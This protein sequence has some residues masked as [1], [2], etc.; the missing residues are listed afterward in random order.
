MPKRKIQPREPPALPPCPGPKL[1]AF[2]HQNAQIK[3]LERLDTD[4]EGESTTQACVYKVEIESKVY[5][6]KIFKFFD[7]ETIRYYWELQLRGSVP[8]NEIIYYTD[9]FFAECRAYGRIKEARVTRG[10]REK[11]AVPCHGYLFLTKDDERRLKRD[12]VSLGSRSLSNELRPPHLDTN[13][14]RAIVKDFEPRPSGLNSKNVRLALRKLKRLNDIQVYN[15]DVTGWVPDALGEDHAEAKME[16]DMVMFDEAVIEDKVKTK[17]K[18][19]LERRQQPPRK[20]K[21]GF[22]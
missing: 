16:E 9:P 1:A 5:A 17:A 14:V 21:S 20:A 8:L 18:A 22:R 6:L 10:I 11:L 7:P 19:L 4:G 2:R 3:W 12:G 13:L 15:G